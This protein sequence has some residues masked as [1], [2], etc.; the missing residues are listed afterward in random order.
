MP[1]RQNTIANTSFNNS[2]FEMNEL[3]NDSLKVNQKVYQNKENL[4]RRM[5]LSIIDTIV[6]ITCT[7]SCRHDF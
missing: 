3:L 4:K 2:S 6:L 1:K 7:F 5:T